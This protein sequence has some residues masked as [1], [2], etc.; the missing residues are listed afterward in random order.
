MRWPLLLAASVAIG[1]A[2]PPSTSDAGSDAAPPDPSCP[3][4]DAST[5]QQ[6]VP[7][8]T[9]D[10]V[11]I[12][13]KRCNSTCHAPGVGPWPLTNYQD[14]LDWADI[15]GGYI[16]QCGMP[17]PD[18]GAGD[19]NMTDQERALVLNWLACGAPNN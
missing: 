16:E 1:C 10:V 2:P 19:G 6:P 15:I 5:C 8:Y 4:I 7:S 11:P 12:L 9:T 13:D 14:V 3:F 18:A 17:P